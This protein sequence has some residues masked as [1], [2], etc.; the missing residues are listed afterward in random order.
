MDNFDVLWEFAED[1]TEAVSLVASNLA[2]E[3]ARSGWYITFRLAERAAG[4]Y[5]GTLA[6]N[7]REING[8]LK[9]PTR[10]EDIGEKLEELL[11]ELERVCDVRPPILE[12]RS[13]RTARGTVF[14]CISIEGR[15][16]IDAFLLVVERRKVAYTIVERNR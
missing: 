8:F 1:S 7:L 12:R 5:L 15:L 9:Q 6:V 2:A 3:K 16:L 10:L 11:A 4:R 14:I 13:I